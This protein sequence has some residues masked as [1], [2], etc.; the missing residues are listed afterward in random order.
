MFK[1]FVI[2]ALAGAMLFGLTG[3]GNKDLWDTQY[4]F[5][6]AVIALPNGEIVEGRVES[7][8]DYENSDQIQVKING[9]T[10]LVHSSNIA[11]I[12]DKEK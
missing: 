1:K 12:Y 9:A 5:N 4:V 8:T 2:S 3:C 6:Q 7:W 10:Y 11:L